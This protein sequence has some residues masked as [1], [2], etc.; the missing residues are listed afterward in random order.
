MVMTSGTDGAK[1]V[2]T[3]LGTEEGYSCRKNITKAS[4]NFFIYAAFGI[5]WGCSL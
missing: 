5:L 3:I 4:T 1:K 2:T